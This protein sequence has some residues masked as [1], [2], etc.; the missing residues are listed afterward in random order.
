[1]INNTG[2][3]VK[4]VTAAL[5]CFRLSVCVSSRSSPSSPRRAGIWIDGW[6]AA[7]LSRSSCLILATILRRSPSSPLSS[8][9]VGLKRPEN[10]HAILQTR[11]SITVRREDPSRDPGRRETKEHAALINERHAARP[12]CVYLRSAGAA[13]TTTDA[14]S[15]SF[16]FE[17]SSP[18]LPL[19]NQRYERDGALPR[20]CSQLFHVAALSDART[21]E[22]DPRTHRFRRRLRLRVLDLGRN[23]V[24][25]NVADDHRQICHSRSFITHGI[26]VV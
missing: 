18:A 17:P 6:R 12:R 5:K 8:S 7:V 16:V 9:R 4:K 26:C 23:N 19:A 11:C 3:L 14:P 21:R 10:G 22:T 13:T 25:A 15:P 24:A 2:G 1:M 20:D